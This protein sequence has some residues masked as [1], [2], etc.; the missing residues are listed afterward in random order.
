MAH[1][2][3]RVG[4]KRSLTELAMVAP[5]AAFVVLFALIPVGLLFASSISAVGGLGGLGSLLALP[6]NQRA[7]TNSLLQGGVSAALAVAFGYPAGVFLGRYRWPGRD[8]VRSLL[9]VP[10]LLPSLIVVLGIEDLFGAGGLLTTPA[11]WLQFLGHGIPGIVAANLIFNVPLVVI[12]TAAGCETA[13]SDLEETV[14]T[15]GGSPARAYRDAWGRPTWI[16]AAAGGLL[17]F[18]FSALSF[19]PPLLL[20]GERCYTVEAR[21]WSLDQ[22]LLAP[23]EAGGLALV[24]VVL[25]LAPTLGYLY[26]VRR[27]AAPSGRKAPPGRP[28]VWTGTTAALAFETVAVLAGVTIL[29]GAVLFRTL[30]PDGGGGAGSAWTTLFG[31]ATSNRLGI[32]IPSAIANTLLFAVAAAGITVVLAV[33]A[34]Y[35]VLRKPGRSSGLG[36]L[37]FVPLLLSPVVL[38]LSLATFWRPLLGGEGSVWALVIV[39]QTVLALPFAL[40]SLGI[41]LAGLSAAGREAAESLGAGRFSAFLD[42]DLPRVRDGLVTASLFAFALGL[43]EFTAT[44]FLVTPRFTTLPVALYGLIGAR[45]L[46]A[47]DA[48]A[49]LLLLLSLLV[50]LVISLGGRRVEL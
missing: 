26:L 13:S 21:I 28:L 37:L 12:L 5:I 47:A 43:G 40:Q 19:A 25:F 41:P 34:A 46:P 49:G 17:T 11:P 3:D 48:A 7:V 33:P 23:S 14:V 16:G 8:L 2:R 50:F 29:L 1:P 15:L 42:A 36:L 35:A 22:I 30:V 39:S 38:A 31:P 4:M 20:C 18:L 44:Y 27:L 6:L 10:F 32:G 9:L 45:Q 24:M